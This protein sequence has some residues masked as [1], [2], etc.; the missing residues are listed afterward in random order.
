[1]T[2]RIRQLLDELPDLVAESESG[3]HVIKLMSEDDARRLRYSLYHA[4]R[5]HTDESHLAHSL[6]FRV[7]GSN[8]IISPRTNKSV[9]AILDS[10]NI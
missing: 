2:S 10:V 5:Q 8:L 6:S 3:A 4:R 1:M 7:V 9:E